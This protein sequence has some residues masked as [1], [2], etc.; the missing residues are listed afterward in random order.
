MAT[1]I[2]SAFKLEPDSYTHSTNKQTTEQQ[3]KETDEKIGYAAPTF[4]GQ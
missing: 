2:Q 3:K 4:D 1:T